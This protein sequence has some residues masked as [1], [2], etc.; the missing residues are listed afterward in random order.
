MRHTR[1]RPTDSLPAAPRDRARLQRGPGLRLDT[2][3]RAP[4][5][6]EQRGA[7]GHVHRHLGHHLRALVRRAGRAVPRGVPSCRTSVFAVSA[8]AGKPGPRP[9]DNRDHLAGVSVFADEDFTEYGLDKRRIADLRSWVT[10][11]YD[12]L[13]L[14]LVADLT[15]DEVP[16]D[17]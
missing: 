9:G 5:A 17:L 10:G 4:R 14:R 7:P 3:R 15:D 1:S 16:D 6:D 11:W 8:G 2:L 13:A 12:D